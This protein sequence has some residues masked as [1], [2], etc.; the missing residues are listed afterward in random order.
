METGSGSAGSS[1]STS[2]TSRIPPCSRVR[3]AAARTASNRDAGSR[4]PT[5]GPSI[6]SRRRSP[7]TD[8][9]SVAL[10]TPGGPATSTPRC[11]DAP[12]V[13]S[14]SDRS[15]A[16]ESHCSSTSAWSPTPTRSSRAT[17]EIAEPSAP[18]A[19]PAPAVR[20]AAA[21]PDDPDAWTPP[22]AGP[23]GKRELVVVTAAVVPAAAA[24]R[25]AVAVAAPVTTAVVGCTDTMP[26]G[27][28]AVTVSS[29]VLHCAPIVL[30]R[31]RVVSPVGN[32][33]PR[34][35]GSSV[36]ESPTRTTLPSSADRSTRSA[37]PRPAGGSPC[38]SIDC[39]PVTCAARTVTRASSPRPQLA[40]TTSSTTRIPLGEPGFAAATTAPVVRA[41][42]ISIASHSRIPSARITSGCA[43]TM[44][45]RES[46]AEADSRRVRSRSGRAFTP[47]SLSARRHGPAVRGRRCA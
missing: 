27:T 36:T 38:T 43:R 26:S 41:P 17:A 31:V 4:E 19:L 12:S 13:R 22:A 14:S 45:R 6:T 46:A 20:P 47:P 23:A 1:A 33:G 32:C 18:S 34:S 15:S 37:T 42:T 2:V 10:P 29:S 9:T 11:G 39:A 44:P 3:S 21:V 16:S 30:R 28:V 8:R 35:R 24:V 7:A 40:A 25:G 5:D